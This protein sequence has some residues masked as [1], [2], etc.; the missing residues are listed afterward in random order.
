MNKSFNLD[1][2]SKEM[3]KI[4][5]WCCA[6]KRIPCDIDGKYF[7]GRK[8]ENF[9]IY[10]LDEVV[11][12]IENSNNNLGLTFQLR[13]D[14]FCIDLDNCFENPFDIE[15]KDWANPIIDY[16]KTQN[17]TIEYSFSGLGLHIFCKTAASHYG[18]KTIKLKLYKVHK[19]WEHLKESKD[20]I[21]VFQNGET[22]RVTGKIYQGKI[23]HKMC[24]SSK[25]NEIIKNL[26]KMESIDIEKIEKQT[27]YYKENPNIEKNKD[28][29]NNCFQ[30]VKTTISIREILKKYDLSP[31]NKNKMLCP[32][33]NEDTPSFH[34]YDYSNLA[35]CFGCGK[36]LSVI[37]FVME[38]EN[39]TNLEAVRKIDEMF[40]LGIDF[41]FNELKNEDGIIYR[42][43]QNYIN[44]E[45]GFFKL[46][47]KIDKEGNEYFEEFKLQNEKFIIVG[48]YYNHN[49]KEKG[50]IFLNKKENVS[51]PL[52]ELSTKSK[53]IN[54]LSRN[55][56]K[57]TDLN[58]KFYIDYIH[59]FRDLNDKIWN[60]VDYTDTLGWIKGKKGKFA[61]YD[62]DIHLSQSIED[63]IE[64]KGS[65]DEWKKEITK[66][67]KN[68]F[69][70][71][72]ISSCV[73]SPLLEP[74][75]RRMIGIGL[76]GTSRMGKTAAAHACMS[77]WSNP[78]K[79]EINGDSSDL[80]LQ[81]K[82]ATYNNLPMYF[83]EKISKD[84]KNSAQEFSRMIYG[85]F[86]NKQGSKLNPDGTE[87]ICYSWNNLILFSAEM[88]ILKD[89]MNKGAYTRLMEFIN[90]N[91]FNSL[92]DA[93]N[94]Y[95][96]S[97]KNY[98]FGNKVIDIIKEIGYQ[99]LNKMLEENSI[100]NDSKVPDH[101]WS[102]EN[103]AIGDY[104]LNK[105]LGLETDIKKSFERMKSIIPLLVDEKD[106]QTGNKAI[107]IVTNFVMVNRHKIE[108]LDFSKNTYMDNF[109]CIGKILPNK[110]KIHLSKQIIKKQ[111]SD[112][113]FDNDKVIQDWISDKVCIEGK[114]LI[115]GARPLTLTFDTN[116]LGILD[117][118]NVNIEDDA[119]FDNDNIN[120][121]NDK[122]LLYFNR[123]TITEQ[124]NI[125]SKLNSIVEEKEE[126]KLK[127]TRGNDLHNIITENEKKDSFFD[128]LPGIQ[129]KVTIKVLDKTNKS[130]INNER[131][132]LNTND[133]NIGKNLFFTDDYKLF[134]PKFTDNNVIKTAQNF[135]NNL[136]LSINDA[137]K[138]VIGMIHDKNLLTI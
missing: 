7:T 29:V 34:V 117:S 1:G 113:G 46:I 79:L 138:E 47:E 24:K 98:G 134:V 83:D 69:F 57:C 78:K 107:D 32:F 95:K 88:K 60:I 130:T 54:S 96:W 73:F 90:I 102:I 41:S 127:V 64:T 27:K 93:K 61:P 94:I 119:I 125:I 50:I 104:I 111:L 114:Q 56:I 40:N 48:E 97:E 118:N 67:R 82:A 123:M 124:K 135:I 35:H 59:K 105:M 28:F 71:F 39:C 22:I 66:L 5:T 131:I 62:K 44:N 86:N 18:F 132:D 9:P 43:P 126:E 75:Q 74:L 133:T 85:L 26:R 12:N 51:I 42:V 55:G 100:K 99:N 120:D 38:K 112:F 15:P 89:Q 58:Y 109:E 76:I 33:H 14:I 36:H 65:F 6:D 122:V 116:I 110:N 11:N 128:G 106:T 20:G 103:A 92:E 17:V 8:K 121:L 21:D 137:Y 23:S 53:I 31:D 37:D 45:N 30:Q 70:N 72:L 87:R 3:K 129:N 16:A 49:N 84:L 19:Q 52:T 91:A 25:F 136:F 115:N 108:N 81:R 80:A 68:D 77:L 4:S 10:S 13:G 101:I 63:L 2:I